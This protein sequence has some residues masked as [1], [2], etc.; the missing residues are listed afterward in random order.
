M[1]NIRTRLKIN[2]MANLD[3][4]DVPNKNQKRKPWLIFVQ[5]LPA[6]YV[7]NDKE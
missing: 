4:V 1:T 7:R 3:K 5:L 6:G 2:N